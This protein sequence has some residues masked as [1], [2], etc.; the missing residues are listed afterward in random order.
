MKYSIKKRLSRT[1]KR[2]S[3]INKRVSA[4]A[5]SNLQIGRGRIGV[6]PAQAG[7]QL[8]T[9]ERFAFY[10][11]TTRGYQCSYSPEQAGYY[12]TNLRN[13]YSST[14]HTHIFRIEDLDKEKDGLKKIHYSTKKKDVQVEVGKEVTLKYKDIFN[15]LF[16]KNQ[17]LTK[18]DK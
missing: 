3:R 13:D 6:R 16:S 17:S 11:Y 15:W 8:T 4:K 18:K 1:N 10:W 14:T 7:A 9:L 12:F 5:L 2:V